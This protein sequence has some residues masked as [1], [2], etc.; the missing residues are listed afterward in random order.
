VDLA[1]QLAVGEGT[2]EC[3]AGRVSRRALLDD[4]GAQVVPERELDLAATA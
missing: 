3:G 4:C 2:I 1:Q